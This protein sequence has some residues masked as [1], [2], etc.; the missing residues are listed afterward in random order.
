MIDGEGAP[1]SGVCAR[2]VASADRSSSPALLLLALLLWCAG[3]PPSPAH[4]G[5]GWSAPYTSALD[6]GIIKVGID[7]NAGGVI[8]YLSPSGSPTNL[9]NTYDLGRGVQRS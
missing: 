4:A 2:R 5:H 7:A 9:L 1:E 6:N 8:S 3:V